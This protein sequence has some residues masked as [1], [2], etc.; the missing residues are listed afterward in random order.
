MYEP[1]ARI[2]ESINSF[3]IDIRKNGRA[4]PVF[5]SSISGMLFAHS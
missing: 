1:Y 5:A 2:R 4:D 3:L